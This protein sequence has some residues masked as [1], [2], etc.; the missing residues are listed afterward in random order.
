MLTIHC[1]KGMGTL[2]GMGA[3]AGFGLGTVG[4]VHSPSIDGRPSG[5][6]V[7]RVSALRSPSKDGAFFRTRPF[8]SAATCS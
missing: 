8:R 3:V 4:A 1:C 7:E 5:C 6:P 2:P